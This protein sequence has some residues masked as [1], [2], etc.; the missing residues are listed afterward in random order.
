MGAIEHFLTQGICLE[1]AAGEKLRVTGKLND[2][3]R[4]AI[5]AQKAQLIHELQWKE[6][7]SLLAIVAPAHDPPI[8]ELWEIRKAAKLDLSAAICSYR[9]M[10]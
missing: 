1:L 8:H 10:T 5:K 3:L 6:F 9:L 4:D 2:S 7:E